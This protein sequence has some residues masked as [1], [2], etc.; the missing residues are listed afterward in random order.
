[1]L[2]M[3][4]NT[5]NRSFF[6]TVLLRIAYIVGILL[7]ILILSIGI[8]KYVPTFFSYISNS[9]SSISDIWKPREGLVISSS[10]DS[11]KS[12]ESIR[13]IWS[14]EVDSTGA[15]IAFTCADDLTV[16]YVGANGSKFPIECGK[17]FKLGADVHSASFVLTVETTN[18]FADAEFSIVETYSDQTSKRG[19]KT[20]TVTSSVATAPVVST[21]TTPTLVEEKLVVK[22]IVAKPS[23]PATQYVA[24]VYTP[25]YY[26][27][28][29]LAV[30][31][32]KPGYVNSFG[33]FVQST[34]VRSSQ[35]S[36]VQIT[37]GNS[38]GTPTGYWKLSATLPSGNGEFNSLPLA[39]LGPGASG[40]FTLQ[41]GQ[42]A[43]TGNYSIVVRADSNNVVS[44]FNEKNNDSHAMI[45]VT[46]GSSA[47]TGKA[48]L[49][50]RI[51]S[52]DVLSN[53]RAEV[54]FEIKNTGGKSAN[55]WGFQAN[56]PTDDNDNY[57]SESTYDL[58][59]GA[60]TVFTLKFN[61]VKDG[62]D[63]EIEVDPTDKIDESNESNNSD[64]EEVR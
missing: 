15:S 6:A 12:G 41:M 22:P 19:S 23:K 57:K 43:Q 26:G 50:V 48:D 25:V 49:S 35:V 42:I 38:G 34:T 40:V 32:V 27:P 8:S 24:P 61:N 10:S 47:M 58:A 59:P 53:D 4:N 17:E 30:I 62:D 31:S 36:A 46:G 51:A 14:D 37:V 56:L 9:F 16:M 1:M 45:N 33:Q 11:I 55:N 7:A 39:P 60:T 28:A 63:I 21:T 29:D 44:E 2:P 52:I 20:I 3:E 64:S 5:D 13:L 18:G 54:K